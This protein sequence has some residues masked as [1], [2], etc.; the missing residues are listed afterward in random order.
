MVGEMTAYECHF[1]IEDDGVEFN[2]DF[3]VFMNFLGFPLK[4]GCDLGHLDVLE[5]GFKRYFENDTKV[6]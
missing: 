4:E 2:P 3:Y 6:N 1:P 5:Q